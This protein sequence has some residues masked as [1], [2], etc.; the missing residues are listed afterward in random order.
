MG[1]RRFDVSPRRLG[2][3]GAFRLRRVP[4]RWGAP[5]ALELHPPALSAQ[6]EVVHGLDLVV[7][8][9]EPVEILQ[10][11]RP[12]AFDRD[13]VIDLEVPVRVAAADDAFRIA[14]F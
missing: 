7:T 2:L 9:A 5:A 10:A 4:V 6:T 13:V 3:A 8:N 14:H 12:A 11:A 1:P